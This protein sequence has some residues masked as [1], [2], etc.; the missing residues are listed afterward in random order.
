MFTHSI[1]IQYSAGIPGQTK[2]PRQRNKRN[3]KLG[4]E[5]KL[6]LFVDDMI[7]YFKRPY[8]LPQKTLRSGKN[9]CQNR[10]YKN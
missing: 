9:F 1:L 3:T 6:S 5:V 2:K 4:K 10:G 8:Q 7:P